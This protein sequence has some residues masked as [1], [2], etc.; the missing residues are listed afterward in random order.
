[1]SGLGKLKFGVF[2]PFYAFKED[3]PQEHF[4]QLRKTVLECEKLGYSSVWLDDHLMYKDWPI[5]ECWTTLSALAAQT[6]KIRLVTM[7]SCNLH[8]NPAVLAKIAASVDVLSGGRLEFGL[9]AGS[10]GI[11]HA[12]YG[13]DFPKLS[14]RTERLSEA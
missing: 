3:K 4:S 14:A 2:L 11:E 5:L 1:M 12:A 8:R 10:E 13:L 6:N 9:G 7:V